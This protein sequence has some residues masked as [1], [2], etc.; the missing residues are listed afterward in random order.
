MAQKVQ[1]GDILEIPTKKGLAY[2]QFSHYHQPP[3]HFGAVIRILPGLFLERPKDFQ[4]LANQKELYY[5]LF[6][7]KAAVNRNI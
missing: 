1:L 7:V 6:P 3:P 5:T 4:A 2:V